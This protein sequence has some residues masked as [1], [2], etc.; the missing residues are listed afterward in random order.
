MSSTDLRPAAPVSTE[1]AGP[2]RSTPA[3]SHPVPSALPVSRPA[4]PVSA[5]VLELLDRAGASLLHASRTGDTG[6]R[7]VTAHLGALRA[8]AAVLAARTTPGGPSRPRS[9]WQVLPGLAPELGEWALFFAGSARRRA[10]VERGD[11]SLPARE[12]DDLLRQA[13][14]FL[15]LVHDLL[16]APRR[17]AL[18]AYLAPA[19][20]GHRLT[21]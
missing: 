21:G 10:V 8:A 11:R 20:V 5:T 7:Y 13:E 18:P 15:D 6:E 16:G 2:A 14:T 19:G 12:A 4:A 3:V 1:P 9:V 17:L